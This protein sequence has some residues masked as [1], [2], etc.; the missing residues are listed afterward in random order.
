MTVG[1]GGRMSR[2]LHVDLVALR[3]ASDHLDVAADEL[4]VGHGDSND[5]IGNAQAGWIGSSGAALATTAAKWAEESAAHYADII[6]HAADI[7]SAAAR[8]LTTDGDEGDQIE[9][10]AAAM[11]L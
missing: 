4:R 5:R 11:G 8:Y 7:R 3:M 6:G 1:P 10:T 9:G 2:D